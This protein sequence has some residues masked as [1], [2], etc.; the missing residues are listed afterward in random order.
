MTNETDQGS[1]GVKGL[2]VWIPDDLHRK[3]RIKCLQNNKTSKSV[4]IDFIRLYIEDDNDGQ[5]E[6]V[7]KTG[8]GKE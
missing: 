5:N 3:F 2:M 1:Q 6:G 8:Q 7:S 4:I